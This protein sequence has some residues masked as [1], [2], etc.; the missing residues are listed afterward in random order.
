VTQLEIPNFGLLLKPFIDSVPA[1]AVP[2]FLAGLEREAANRYR[3]WAEAFEGGKDV[4]LAC[5]ASEDEIADTIE[6]HF[7]ADAAGRSAIEAALPG[8]CALYVSTFEGFSVRDQLCMQADAERQGSR[9][10]QGIASTQTD[11]VIREALSRCERLEIE[12]A[13]AVEQLLAR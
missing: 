8:A 6:K 11:P 10:W 4:L 12:S 13:E 1:P 3:A 9:T 2:A 7:P 5:A